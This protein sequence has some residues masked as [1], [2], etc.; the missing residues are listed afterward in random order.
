MTASAAAEADVQTGVQAQSKPTVPSKA[1][2]YTVQVASVQS[3]QQADTALKQL[4]DNGYAAYT[5]QTTVGG[6]TWYRI[7]IGYFDHAEATHELM[8]RLRS[9][10]FD[11]ILIKF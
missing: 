9:D 5:V 7:R 1:T 2:G 11:P 4:T 6:N 10:H 8:D 3:V